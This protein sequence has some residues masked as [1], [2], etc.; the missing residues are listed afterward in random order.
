MRTRR[1]HRMS[2]PE[3]IRE[4]LLV[5]L[6]DMRIARHLSLQ[7]EPFGRLVVTL[8]QERSPEPT[9]AVGIVTTGDGSPTG[10][11]S[12]D[13]PVTHAVETNEARDELAPSVTLSNLLHPRPG[14][15]TH[16]SSRWRSTPWVLAPLERKR[17]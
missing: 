15:R 12:D 13:T 16:A 2:L 3:Q 17:R 8:R 5:H 14:G 1:S 4:S 11:K 6:S 10:A 7:A 9:G